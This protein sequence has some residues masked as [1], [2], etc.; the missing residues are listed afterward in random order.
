VREEGRGKKGMGGFREG[1][2]YFFDDRQEI[3]KKPS[4]V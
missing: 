1:A 3:D 4:F 2:A